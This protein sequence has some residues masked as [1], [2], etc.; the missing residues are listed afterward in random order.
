MFPKL[1]HFFAGTASRPFGFVEFTRADV[2][3][4]AI[5]TFVSSRFPNARCR[6]NVCDADTF[7]NQ[8]GAQMREYE[9]KVERKVYKRTTGTPRNR[10]QFT[11]P[12]TTPKTPRASG[13]RQP[14][15][16]TP[17]DP[18]RAGSNTPYFTTPSATPTFAPPSPNSSTQQQPQQ[19]QQGPLIGASGLPVSPSSAIYA[20]GN[21]YSYMPGFYHPTGVATFQDPMTGCTYYS[22]TPSPAVYGMPAGPAAPSS[23]ETPTR[24]RGNRSRDQH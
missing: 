22:Y 13:H 3:D 11:R 23:A 2:P 5:K 21:A 17:Q 18:P 24:H 6:P 19:Q 7:A 20:P 4:R 16:P 10:S 15:R 1:T 9:L 8:N 14:T 12:S